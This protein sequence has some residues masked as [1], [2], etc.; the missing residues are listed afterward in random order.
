MKLVLSLCAMLAG[1]GLAAAATGPDYKRP[2]ANLPP[3]YDEKTA[4]EIRWKPAEPS[5]D[6][7]RGAW[8]ETFGDES[9]NQLEHDAGQ[10]NFEVAAAV[11]RLAQARASANVVR[12][13]FWPS[14]DLSGGATRQR[15]SENR[16]LNGY[17]AHGTRIYNDF[18]AGLTLGWE[19]DLW[20]RVRRASEASVA[21]FRASAA[22]L[23]SLRLL[24]EA[25]TAS[26]YFALRA[27]DSDL[28]LL[29]SNL[30]AQTRALELVRN[31][32]VGGLGT[33][34]DVAEAETRVR[35]TEAQIP[36][37]ELSRARLGHALASLTARTPAQ[38][39]V[40]ARPLN[41]NPPIVTAGI[42]AELLERRPDVASAEQ[43][44][45][46]ANASIGVA[47]AAFFPTFRIG[48][49]AG[50]DSLDAGSVFSWPSRL[51]SIGP[52][53]TMPIF[54]G[55][56]LTG[57]LKLAQ[58]VHAEAEANYKQIV[59][60]AVQEVED[61]LSA[62]RLLAAQQSAEELATESA[63]RAL[64]ISLN[65]YQSGLTTYLDVATALTTVLD[66][67]RAVA[68]LRGQRHVAAVSLIK[69]LGGG[70]DPVSATFAKV[71][72]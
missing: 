45:I 39:S 2:A 22:D 53:V 30:V 37:S 51:W 59:L 33:D 20:G 63:N 6:K 19:L 35:E 13:D 61:N 21:Q 66:R 58:A 52:G 4:P 55:Q 71:A 28:G 24:I 50:F 43:R 68:E 5:A 31:R 3:A 16:D 72:K 65:R 10:S 41:A 70:W 1:A 32:R 23:A 17:P 67:E 14:V 44:M 47:K 9:L 29:R 56:R 26:D 48:G 62:Q 57:R 34:L 36:A 25:E 27:L 54:E 49:L 69:A 15:P 46:A 18:T 64:A 60:S 7:T 42:P 8:W 40:E 11:A 38:L 12:A